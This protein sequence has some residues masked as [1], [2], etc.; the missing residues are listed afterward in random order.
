M[1]LKLYRL[2]NKS[3]EELQSRIDNLEKEQKERKLNFY[4]QS[5]K[6][7]SVFTDPDTLFIERW[8]EQFGNQIDKKH[9]I[10]INADA[11]IWYSA[12][13]QKEGDDGLKE[14]QSH[15]QFQS[16]VNDMKQFWKECHENPSKKKIFK[17]YTLEC[18]QE[19]DRILCEESCAFSIILKLLGY[20]LMMNE[21]DSLILNAKIAHVL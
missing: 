3:K 8:Y 21:N 7:L 20:D 1:K 2:D 14:L 5:G 9:E 19:E 17:G 11:K 4:T 15:P 13:T 18:E 10:E 16:I 6:G 12:K